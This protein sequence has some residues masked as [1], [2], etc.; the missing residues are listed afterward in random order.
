MKMT[1]VTD[2]DGNIVAAHHGEAP[3]PDTSH[4]LP[5][6]RASAGLLAGPGQ[7][8]E[9]LDVPDSIAT[10]TSPHELESQLKAALKKR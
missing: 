2:K 9:V 8:L 4:V 6:Y 7:Q 3:S 1:V 5:E 10:V